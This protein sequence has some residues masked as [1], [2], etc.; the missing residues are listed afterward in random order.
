MK[1]ITQA[2]LFLL[3]KLLTPWRNRV[4]PLNK[5]QEIQC[6]FFNP[7]FVLNGIS[8]HIYLEC[9]AEFTYIISFNLSLK[10]LGGWWINVSKKCGPK[11]TS[12]FIHI[13]FYQN[14][15]S[16]A[17]NAQHHFTRFN[18]LLCNKA[19]TFWNNA[20]KLIYMK[21]VCE[22]STLSQ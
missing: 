21:L 10:L 3:V 5:G 1:P 17:C 8:A 18:L 11:N 16:S 2:L 12:V 22:I 4:I 9:L 19:V 6:G 20:C 7:L 14:L 15:H 13:R